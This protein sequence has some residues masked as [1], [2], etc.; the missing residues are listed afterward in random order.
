MV[1]QADWGSTY[2]WMCEIPDF[3]QDQKILSKDIYINIYSDSRAAIESV[4]SREL[5]QTFEQWD[6]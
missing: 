2:L 5:Q 6:E 1:F 3:K 4:G